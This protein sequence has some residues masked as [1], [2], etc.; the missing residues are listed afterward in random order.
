MA[1]ATMFILAMGRL[2]YFQVFFFHLKNFR[3]AVGTFQLLLTHVVF[4]AE[5]DRTGA[6]LGLKFYIPPT[7]FFLLRVDRGPGCKT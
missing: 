2:G 6:A 4:M 3:M 5:K 1:N 7:N